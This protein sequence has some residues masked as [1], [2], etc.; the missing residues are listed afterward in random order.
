MYCRIDTDVISRFHYFSAAKKAKV[1]SRNTLNLPIKNSTIHHHDTY[2][3]RCL[4][5]ALKGSGSVA[6]NPMVGCVIVNENRIIGEGW[7]QQYGGPHAEVMAIQS[8][9]ETEKLTSSRLYV[10]LEPCSHFG[11]TPPCA[12][13]IL[14]HHIPEV[15]IASMDDHSAVAGSGI[16]RL[17]DHG[18]DVTVGVLE[19]DARRLNK[20]FFSFHQLQRP[21]VHLK[22]AR[23][24]DGFLAPENGRQWISNAFSKRLTHKWRHNYDA[25][26]IGKRTALLDD[27]NLN[28]RF[29]NG[30]PIQRVVIDPELTLPGDLQIFTDGLPTLVLNRL[31]ESEDQAVSYLIPEG[32][33]FDPPS[34]LDILYKRS[35]QSVL[36]E[37]GAITLSYFLESDH[38]DEATVYESQSRLGSG[39]DAPKIEQ[40]PQ[41]TTTL[42]ENQILQYYRT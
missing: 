7:H 32:D 16:Q 33:R 13:L 34:I 42:G 27:P 28:D 5:L 26:L 17:R 12:D 8:V 40:R 18:V 35:I 3:K 10:N 39:L 4:D 37:G 21:Y 25:I 41:L 31:R 2:M 22:W 11:K 20:A 29:W 30:S 1:P 23:S 19:Q 9:T 24:L 6:P 15:Y 38:W 14:K 36:V